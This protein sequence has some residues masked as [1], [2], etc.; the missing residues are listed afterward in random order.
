MYQLGDIVAVAGQSKRLMVVAIDGHRLTVAWKLRTGEVREKSRHQSA[1]V[2]L[3]R[4]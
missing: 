4:A 3:Q 2:L 1:F